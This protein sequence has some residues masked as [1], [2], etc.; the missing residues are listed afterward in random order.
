MTG[1]CR[2]SLENSCIC[3]TC[4]ANAWTTNVGAAHSSRCW[5]R[6]LHC[7]P[8]CAISKS[9]SD[10]AVSRTA[11]P[12]SAEHPHLRRGRSSFSHILRSDWTRLLPQGR[13]SRARRKPPPMDLTSIQAAYRRYARVYDATFGAVF[14]AGRKRILTQL[15][16]HGGQRLLEVGV[17][18]GISLP[19]YRRDNTIVGIDI[20]TDMPE[21]HGRAH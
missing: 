21:Q 1:Y 8:R 20:S 7:G 19:G 5:E 18:T 12:Y 2:S 4:T 13:L 11:T 17:G 6:T 3:L 10:S 14:A 16:R 15:N 9:S